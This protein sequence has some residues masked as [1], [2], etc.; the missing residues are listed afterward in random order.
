MKK[1]IICLLIILP[2]TLYGQNVG[3]G[4][5]NTKAT[6]H[7]SHP[8]TSSVPHLVLFDSTAG[9]GEYIRLMQKN[10]TNNWRLVTATNHTILQ[11]KNS[12][13]PD[14][15]LSMKTNGFVGI[16][17]S[18]PANVFQVNSAIPAT[19]LFNGGGSSYLVLAENNNSLGYF[20]SYA[21]NVN[22]IDFGTHSANTA[23]HVNLLTRGQIRMQLRNND[24]VGIGTTGTAQQSLSI[25]GGLLVDYQNSHTQLSYGFFGGVIPG[26]TRNSIQFG[27]TGGVK[28]GSDRRQFSGQASHWLNFYLQDSIY[29]QLR[30]YNLNIGLGGLGGNNT[31]ALNVD[32]D[33]WA[34]TLVISRGSFHKYLN[35]SY[36]VGSHTTD[37]KE[38]T[39][40]FGYTFSQPPIIHLTLHQDNNPSYTDTFAAN[41]RQVLNDRMIVKIVRF[42]TNANGTGWGQ[43]LRLDWWATDNN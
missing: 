1:I 18:D 30:A 36:S 22:D 7:I 39:I 17:T 16:N 28:I 12:S 25:G 37:T 40:F 11:V 4:S 5:I 29:M 19:V 31:L 32:G 2:F 38:V 24:Y 3:L 8:G 23:G 14:A 26:D 27:T 10:S 15:V 42:D 13:E 6:V 34:D 41:L 21:G 33:V 35:G 20:G 9:G 43:N